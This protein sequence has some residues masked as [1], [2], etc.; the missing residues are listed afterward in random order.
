MTVAAEAVSEPMPMVGANRILGVEVNIGRHSDDLDRAS[1]DAGAGQGFRSSAVQVPRGPGLL[2]HGFQAP[3]FSPLLLQE[4]TSSPVPLPE[5]KILRGSSNIKGLQY[6]TRFVPGT[7][8]V[9]SVVIPMYILRA[10]NFLPITSNAITTMKTTTTL[11]CSFLTFFKYIYAP[12]FFQPFLTLFKYICVFVFF[13]PNTQ[14]L[15]IHN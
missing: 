10:E 5:A 4:E 15:F 2:A 1:G 3:P 13:Q 6:S 7:I 12:S 8:L 9:Q 11:L 14:I